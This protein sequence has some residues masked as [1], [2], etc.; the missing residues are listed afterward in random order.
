MSHWQEFLGAQG[1]EYQT[2]GTVTF[3][4]A[5]SP[6]NTDTWMTPL[7]HERLISLHG[8]KAQSFLQG[9]VTCDVRELSEQRWR[10]GA[11]CNLKGRV[12][13]SFTLAAAGGD[14]LLLKLSADLAQSTRD[15]LHKYAVFSRVELAV[16]DQRVVLGLS[17]PDADRL[18]SQHLG[19]AAPAAGEFTGSDKAVVLALENQ[20]FELWINSQAA[21][22]LWQV[23]SADCLPADTALWQQQDIRAGVAKINTA[24]AERYTP[25]DLNYPLIDAVNFKKGCYTG[26]EVVA[27]LHYKAT[28]KKRLYLI[29][30][31][32]EV[33]A[34]TAAVSNSDGKNRGEIVQAL[35]QANGFIALA[36]LPID[37]AQSL[38]LQERDEPIT[39]LDLPYATAEADNSP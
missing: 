28:L 1:A 11:Q 5:T 22:E 34:A 24:T 2:D 16:D 14:E 8:A 18:I 30:G 13:A 12:M 10:Y 4:Q 15:N 19:F 6:N 21:P 9:Q 3:P 33:P 36:V 17:G 38:Y 27:R 31:A 32:G 37:D 39:R 26:Q 25:Q 23:L 29:E 20:R 35:S 7:E